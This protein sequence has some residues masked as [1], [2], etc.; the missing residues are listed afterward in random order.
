MPDTELNLNSQWQLERIKRDLQNYSPE[1]LREM[2]LELTRQQLLMK[3][4]F[5]VW[6]KDPHAANAQALLGKGGDCVREN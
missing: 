3:E 2:V 6:I 5:A 4:L 1:Q